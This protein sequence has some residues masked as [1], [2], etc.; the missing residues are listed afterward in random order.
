MLMYAESLES[1]KVVY[2]AIDNSSSY[3]EITLAYV[4]ECNRVTFG[5]VHHNL[6]S[7]D[8]AMK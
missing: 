5:N 8:F 6:L 7:V 3:Y 1:D 4:R 2:I